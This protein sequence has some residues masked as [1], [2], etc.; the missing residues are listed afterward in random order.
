MFDISDVN[1]CGWRNDYKFIFLCK[2]I[3]KCFIGFKKGR[4]L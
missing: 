4:D 3:V 1:I 2:E